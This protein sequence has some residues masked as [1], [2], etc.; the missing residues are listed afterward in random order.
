MPGKALESR[1]QVNS[2]INWKRARNGKREGAALISLEQA[3]SVLVMLMIGDSTVRRHWILDPAKARNS[4]LIAIQHFDKEL[5]MVKQA[6]LEPK[7][8]QASEY[9]EKGIAVLLFLL[10]FTPVLEVETESPRSCR[11]DP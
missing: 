1:K 2:E 8:S 9:F 10:G 11:Y 6:V 4:R 7:G 5:R 3:D